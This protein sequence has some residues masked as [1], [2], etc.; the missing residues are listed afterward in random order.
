MAY[1]ANVEAHVKPFDVKQVP[2][3]TKA[4]QEKAK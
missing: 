1:C 3:T 4:E 2:M